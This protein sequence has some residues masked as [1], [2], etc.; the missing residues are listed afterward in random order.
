MLKELRLSSQSCSVQTRSH[1][2]PT[3][4]TRGRED[5]RV[6][7]F[8]GLSAGALRA[9]RVVSPRRSSSLATV[10]Q[11]RPES[12]S[13]LHDRHTAVVEPQGFLDFCRSRG[14]R[15]PDDA[16]AIE[17]VMNGPLGCAE[18]D[19]NL[20]RRPACLLQRHGSCVVIVG[21]PDWPRRD[22]GRDRSQV[23]MRHATE[24]ANLL[25]LCS[26]FKWRSSRRT[27]VE[28]VDEGPGSTESG[29]SSYSRTASWPSAR[30][31]IAAISPR[32]ATSCASGRRKASPLTLIAP[33]ATAPPSR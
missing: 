11:D 19:G 29:P 9:A 14:P 13:E 28:T 20:G 7:S 10:F 6:G 21:E 27:L 24:I 23:R 17:P 12:N 18:L 30:V 32:A 26:R 31:R 22:V 5:G 3:R 1:P 4:P 2:A 16:V 8:D 15:A 25:R 33:L